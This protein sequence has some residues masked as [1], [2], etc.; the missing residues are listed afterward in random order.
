M[1]SAGVSM[2]VGIGDFLY[3]TIGLRH[4]M[5]THDRVYVATPYAMILSGRD[6]LVRM[7]PLKC[8]H[9]WLSLAQT[10]QL[11]RWPHKAPFLIINEVGNHYDIESLDP[12][13]ITHRSSSNGE[14]YFCGNYYPE[15]CIA[16]GVS[17]ALKAGEGPYRMM[18]N[19]YASLWEPAARQWMDRY[20]LDPHKAILFHVLQTNLMNQTQPRPTRAVN[21]EVMVTARKYLESHGYQ[22]FDADLTPSRSAPSKH[23]S[24]MPYAHT[25]G[26]DGL[27]LNMALT[28]ICRAVVMQGSCRQ[29][30]MAQHYRKP[31]LVF[32]QGARDTN[33]LNWHKLDCPP[34]VSC[35]PERLHHCSVTFCDECR[36][37]TIPEEKIIEAC[38]RMLAISV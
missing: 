24:D 10:C 27:L 20:G 2:Y 28:R 23:F 36:R 21:D 11:Q 14:G 26:Y 4:L 29:L 33:A 35:Q 16:D 30:P 38:D 18:F 19:D 17:D 1:K 9:E 8:S 12:E 31:T 25:F 7:N 5:E 37:R 3:S 34:F 22:V 6:R 15:Q 32:N 13:Y